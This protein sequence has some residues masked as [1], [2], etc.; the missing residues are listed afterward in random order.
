MWDVMT[1]RILGVI[2]AL[3]LVKKV[4]KEYANKI[5]NSI[6]IQEIQKTILPSSTHILRRNLSF[7]WICHIL[8]LAP[9]LRNG[10]SMDEQ[11][12]K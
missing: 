4:I 8:M 6:N 5:T 9:G 10:L 1:T 11:I 12:R 2:A 7:K 3:C